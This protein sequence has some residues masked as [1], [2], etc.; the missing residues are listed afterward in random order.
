MTT[1][2]QFW[3]EV[4]ETTILE[5]GIFALK[6]HVE[7]RRQKVP[8]PRPLLPNLRS[9]RLLWLQNRL[10]HGLLSQEEREQLVIQ[11]TQSKGLSEEEVANILQVF[12]QDRMAALDLELAGP[13]SVWAA[14][15]AGRVLT[16][17]VQV[18]PRR[19]LTPQP[20][21]IRRAS[22][23]SSN[24]SSTDIYHSCIFTL[25]ASLLKISGRG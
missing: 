14:A 23:I 16:D 3:A 25:I 8:A 9:R 6:D 2:A 1:N 4:I 12:R 17:A 21:P 5:F 11:R 10:R 20:S 18:S 19:A 24:P 22:M 7:R 13:A 15:P